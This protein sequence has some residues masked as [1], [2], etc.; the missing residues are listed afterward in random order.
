MTTF[1]PK[2]DKLLAK[3]GIHP[4]RFKLYL[5]IFFSA[6][7][8]ILAMLL[9]WRLSNNGD[10]QPPTTDPEWCAC[11]DEYIKCKASKDL[12]YALNIS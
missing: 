11:G 10:P 4:R 7:G 3:R 12:W 2:F 9:V 8:L 5:V 1:G 6:L